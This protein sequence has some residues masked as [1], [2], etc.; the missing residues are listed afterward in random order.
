M[1]YPTDLINIGRHYENITLNN[2]TNYKDYWLK[3][4]ARNIER[5]K[6]NIEKMEKLGYKSIIAWECELK[7]NEQVGNIISRIID[8]EN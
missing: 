2:D 3:K 4:F 7:R 6:E 5:D 8:I 1:H